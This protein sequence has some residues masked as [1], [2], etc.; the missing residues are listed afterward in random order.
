MLQ[1]P[2]CA[3]SLAQS[4]Q[5]FLSPLSLELAA[6][7]L[8]CKQILPSPSPTMNTLIMTPLP[9]TH[10]TSARSSPY[11]RSSGTT[12]RCS[13]NSSSTPS[14]FSSAYSSQ[15][16]S[17]FSPSSSCSTQSSWSDVYGSRT[18][19]LQN[20]RCS[21]HPPPPPFPDLLN[22]PPACAAFSS[23]RAPVIS[24]LASTTSKLDSRNG[25]GLKELSNRTTN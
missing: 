24:E 10:R 23:T 7:P 5:C 25:G 1:P 12:S 21:C 15:P 4:T 3:K 6:V 14:S 13:C 16:S 2:L 11:R 18:S 22:S 19:V 8:C 17:L 9:Q 20:T